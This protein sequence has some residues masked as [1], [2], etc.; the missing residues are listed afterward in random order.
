MM[1]A[2][3]REAFVAQILLLLELLDEHEAV[4]ELHQKEFKVSGTCAA[5]RAKLI[6]PVEDDWARAFVRDALQLASLQL[7]REFFYVT[8][9]KP[10]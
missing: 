6:A 3:T 5:D 1:Y 7:H 10:Q 2:A 9:E 4:R 8:P